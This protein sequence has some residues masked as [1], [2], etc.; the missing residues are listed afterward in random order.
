MAQLRHLHPP[1]LFWEP[2]NPKHRTKHPAHPQRFT[3][4]THRTTVSASWPPSP[5]GR[6]GGCPRPRGK[7]R[8]PCGHKGVRSICLP[9]GNGVDRCPMANCCAAIAASPWNVGAGRR[10]AHRVEMSPP[11]PLPARRR[12]LQPFSRFPAGPPA[13]RSAGLGRRAAVGSSP[14][15]NAFPHLL[16]LPPAGPDR[17]SSCCLSRPLPFST[18]KFPF[19]AISVSRRPHSLRVA[20]CPEFLRKQVMDTAVGIIQASAS[21]EALT[22]LRGVSGAARTVTPRGPESSA[23]PTALG[24]PEAGSCSGGE[25]H[26][27]VALWDLFTPNSGSTEE[28]QQRSDRHGGGSHGGLQSPSRCGHAWRQALGTAVPGRCR[29]TSSGLIQPSATSRSCATAR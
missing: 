3:R 11:L 19:T 7:R 26:S 5:R 10:V 15:R 6:A 4:P 23:L 12:N 21:N 17:L 18:Y 13:R 29:R 27:G 16:P 1:R 22:S 8:R 28:R 25:P 9:R 24:A 20:L 14:V 2:A